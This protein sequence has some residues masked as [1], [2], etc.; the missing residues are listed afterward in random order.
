M[1]KAPWFAP[2]VSAVALWAW[3][4]PVL[5]A[6]QVFFTRDIMYFKAPYLAEWA[7]QLRD[8][9]FPLWS[10]R[11][12]GGM[13]LWHH[14]AAELADPLMLPAVALPALEGFSLAIVLHATAACMGMAILAR[15]MGV[16]AWLA[17][18]C[19]VAFVGCGATASLWNVK[20][21]PAAALPWLLLGFLNVA[22]RRGRGVT[23]ALAAA[24]MLLHPDPPMVL[25][26]GVAGL[27][28]HRWRARWCAPVLRQTG[29][30]LAAGALLAAPFLLPAL[31]VVLDAERGG[32]ILNAPQDGEDLSPGVLVESLAPG[33]LG[34]RGHA[35]TGEAAGR[36]LAHPRLVPHVAL[37]GPAWLALAVAV[38]RGRRQPRGREAWL[39]GTG[40][41]LM[42]LGTGVLPGSH[43]LMAAL[44]GRFPD[45]LWLAGSCLWLLSAGR[46]LTSLLRARRRNPPPAAY[47]PALLAMAATPWAVRSA[48]EQLP[49]SGALAQV[50]VQ[51]AQT[52]LL[53]A[54]G[55]WVLAA[56]LVWRAPV[57]VAGP[58]LAAVW[59][60]Q[61]LMCFS[62]LNIT[63][64]ASRLR[65]AATDY[66][67]TGHAGFTLACLNPQDATVPV[68]T[69]VDPLDD[70][71][72]AIRLGVAMGMPHAPVLDGAREVAAADF[73]QLHPAP[74]A[75][76]MRGVL[77][78]L[79]TA[80]V[81]AWAETLGANRVVTPAGTDPPPGTVVNLG[82]AGRYVDVRLPGRPWLEALTGWTRADTPRQQTLALQAAPLP[83]AVVG[84][85]APAAPPSAAP[86]Q[87]KMLRQQDDRVA[88][89][90]NAATEMLVVLHATRARGWHATVDGAPAPL[91]AANLL[92]MAVAVPAGPHTV[93]FAYELP[94]AE[95]G[96]ALGLA[97]VAWL[98]WR[99]AGGWHRGPFVR[100]RGRV[101][102]PRP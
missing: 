29:A 94:W 62:S 17:A 87:Q 67:G 37:G 83:G 89:R 2:C 23:L 75:A 33:A 97:A 31:S 101:V 53:Q 70:G 18:A 102:A 3:V 52:Q 19:G 91:M 43:A 90:V 85:H 42:V 14:P 99:L 16:S 13:P 41:A 15:R 30:A 34:L 40:A 59:A 27:A 50:A 73:S 51:T 20:L 86:P 36:A 32:Q 8:G 78:H 65:N 26:A 88:A 98:A 64:E 58:G 60:L 100:A 46:V 71:D 72:V 74:M 80:G 69:V 28:V 56:L 39:L 48:A 11:L 84:L 57:R 4:L 49:L 61:M 24:W 54:L 95:P 44:G 38:W 47:V 25:A 82:V 12:G 66:L 9:H 6:G 93:Q 92:Q 45:K 76:F 7:R 77:P 96:W 63:T 1:L 22:Q 5:A 55:L 35:G 10:A 21:L 79:D 81:V 68:P